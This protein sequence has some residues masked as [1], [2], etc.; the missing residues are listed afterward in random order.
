LSLNEFESVKHS[1]NKSDVNQCR[2][3]KTM[4][5]SNGIVTTGFID[6]KF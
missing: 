4:T 2:N 5:T 3:A 1:I 6:D